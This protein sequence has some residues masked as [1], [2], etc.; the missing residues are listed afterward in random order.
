M[1]GYRWI[2]YTCIPKVLWLLTRIR[3]SVQCISFIDYYIS[4]PLS[5][6]SLNIHTLPPL[7]YLLV[8]LSCL[9]NIH[10][11]KYIYSSTQSYLLTCIFT[12]LWTALLHYTRHTCSILTDR[13]PEPQSFCPYPLDRPSYLILTK[14]LV[15]LSLPS[16]A[17][18]LVPYCQHGVWRLRLLVG[19]AQGERARLTVCSFTLC[20]SVVR[21]RSWSHAS[22]TA[23]VSTTLA[24]SHSVWLHAGNTA[25]SAACLCAYTAACLCPY[26]AA[27]LCAYTAACLCAYTAACLCAYTAACLCAYTAACLCAYTA[28]C[29]CAYTAACLCAYTAACLC[30]YTAACLCAYTATC[31]CAYT[32]ACLSA[33]LL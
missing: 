31:L 4:T 30:A 27:C 28:A 19:A 21:A 10:T 13:W 17:I 15:E 9:V 3:R 1:S 14:V 29:L 22:C 25:T 18:V 16:Y 6:Y 7:L 23:Q 5:F 26:T 33:C 12:T 8:Y 2:H 20:I 24:A 32:A 11:R